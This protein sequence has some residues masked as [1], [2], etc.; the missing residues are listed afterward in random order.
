MKF[1][2]QDAQL[3]TLMGILLLG[4]M[5]CAE[6][7]DP[8]MLTTAKEQSD[9]LPPDASIQSIML[10][11]AM[12]TLPDSSYMTI[13]LQER[14]AA[15]F[16]ELSITEPEDR[17][18][19][20]MSYLFPG[21]SFEVGPYPS[22]AV[23][24]K[25]DAYH[26]YT[27]QFVGTAHSQVQ[28]AYPEWTIRFEDG[29]DGDYDDIVIGVV[30][31][32]DT[33]S[34]TVDCD[35]TVM[36]GEE[37]GCEVLGLGPS[38][39]VVSWKFDREVVILGVGEG[40]R[41]ERWEGTVVR[42]GDVQAL[43]RRPDGTQYVIGDYLAATILRRDWRWGEANWTVQLTGGECLPGAF[44]S[45]FP[46]GK[47]HR[48]SSCSSHRLEPWPGVDTVQA[49]QPVRIDDGGPNGGAQHGYW[50]VENPPVFRMDRMISYQEDV[51]PGRLKHVV[52]DP[53]QRQQC[54]NAD[55]SLDP[56]PGL[57]L[58]LTLEQVKIGRAHV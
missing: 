40:P 27:E 15:Y 47:N 9:S 12:I 24:I 39:T 56:G 32:P 26:N 49:F 44:I 28:G 45:G 6:T 10:A 18:L 22:G 20:A 51:I 23:G 35:A 21:P 54:I 29:G 33:V 50:Y 30:A 7:I 58:E 1:R 25:V 48:Q 3:G 17:V 14:N 52:A 2:R 5:S 37:A 31:T 8:T 34:A 13:T 11:P 41:G 36:R 42:G 53:I 38:E 16:H 19:Q 43:I 55:P 57:D 4:T 46:G